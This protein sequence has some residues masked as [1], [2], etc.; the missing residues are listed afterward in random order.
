[1]LSPQQYHYGITVTVK[2]LSPLFSR[3]TPMAR[4]GNPSHNLITHYYH[5]HYYYYYY[6]YYYYSRRKL[7]TMSNSLILSFS[8]K[9]RF[10]P[11]YI[12]W[13]VLSITTNF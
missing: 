10:F 4:F 13:N 6:Y 1:M 3:A 11:E 8:F 7:F 12:N 5:Y 2:Q 9:V